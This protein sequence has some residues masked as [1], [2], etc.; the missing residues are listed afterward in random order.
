M[1]KVT[2]ILGLF[3]LAGLVVAQE[4]DRQPAAP[5]AAAPPRDAALPRA[6]AAAQQPLDRLMVQCL[7]TANKGEVAISKFAQQ[8]S[9]N[10]DVQSFA[11][12][13]VKDHSQFLSQLQQFDR[14]GA[15]DSPAET[16]RGATERERGVDRTPGAADPT[17]PR[18]ER[19][20]GRREAREAREERREERRERVAEAR[21][22]VRAARGGLVEKLIEINEE[23]GQ[24]CLATAQRELEQKEGTDF[25]RCYVGM[26]VGA[27]L[28]MVDELSVFKNHASPNLQAIISQGLETSTQ[29]L[30]HA[31]KLHQQ[32]EKSSG[33]ATARRE[34]ATQE[35]QE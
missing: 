2:T 7:T 15:S 26:Q 18:A 20:E 34:G 24:R 19:A 11:A 32:I 6:E 4:I 14:G 3:L 23:I 10:K 8:K 25:D 29:H 33:A 35:K 31:K 28:K 30:A 12:Q 9:Q 21:E 5:R 27:H 17:T 13:M 16:P 1:M 22:T